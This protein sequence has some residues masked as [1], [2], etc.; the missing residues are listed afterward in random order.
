MI[1]KT[2]SKMISK[3]SKRGCGF[4]P[5]ACL[6]FAC[7]PFAFLLLAFSLGASCAHTLSGGGSF[8][9]DCNFP[10]AT[11]WVDDVLVG[12]AASWKAGGRQIR[13]GFHRIEI[14]RPGTYSVFKE[15]DLPVGGQSVVV[16]KL[17][18]TID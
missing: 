18:E 15:I 10:D 12:S 11:V 7:L 16:A 6:P 8:R 13:A 14:R 5:F 3:T 4:P 9:V 17:H 2:T 1:S